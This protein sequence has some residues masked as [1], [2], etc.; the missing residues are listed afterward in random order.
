MLNPSHLIYIPCS[1][2][3]L[4]RR[5]VYKKAKP[6]M[7]PVSL[8]LIRECPFLF[9]MLSAYEGQATRNFP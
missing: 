6:T 7:W 4:A 5:Y 9:W 2:C 1:K 8:L 3:K